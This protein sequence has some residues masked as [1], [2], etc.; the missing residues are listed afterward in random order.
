MLVGVL[1]FQGDY[2][3]HRKILSRLNV[4]C[5]YVNSIE[6]L[7]KTDALII[8]GGESTV[9]SKFIT[10][11]KMEKEIYKY[12]LSK[13]VYGTCAGLI[14][15]SKKCDDKKVVNLGLLDVTAYRNAW[16]RQVHSFED[17]IK[18]NFNSD[19]TKLSFIRA[20]KIKIN[21]N[22]INILGKY[23]NEPVLIRNTRHLGS[24]FHPEVSGDLSVHKYFL[25]MVKENAS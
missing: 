21:S 17:N 10:K 12:S 20:P 11:S 16:G 15:M 7:T 2:F 19:T 8:P 22:T 24:T 18:F 1:S 14:L 25:K 23:D 3:L 13:C 9:I 6:S 4:K 5:L